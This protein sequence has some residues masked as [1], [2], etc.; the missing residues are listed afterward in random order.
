MCNRVTNH[1]DMS[2]F[3]KPGADIVASNGECVVMFHNVLRV[4]HDVLLVVHNV[5]C[6]IAMFYKCFMMFYYV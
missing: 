3:S 2:T 5:S 1:G 6:C 4:F